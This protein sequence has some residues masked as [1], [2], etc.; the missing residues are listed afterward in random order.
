MSQKRFGGMKKRSLFVRAVMNP[1]KKT[2]LDDGLTQEDLSVRA[3]GTG[4]SL[5][6]E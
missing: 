6:D 1:F 2:C 3:Q 4:V 5:V